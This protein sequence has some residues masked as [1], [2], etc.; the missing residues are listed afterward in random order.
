MA[1]MKK[2]MTFLG[3]H[4]LAGIRIR[5]LGLRLFIFFPHADEV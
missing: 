1:L 3:D 2:D 4:L 5:T